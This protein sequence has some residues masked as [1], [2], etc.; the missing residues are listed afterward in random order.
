MVVNNQLLARQTLLKV[1]L[2]D[3]DA[4]PAAYT[5]QGWRV[6]NAEDVYRALS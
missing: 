5:G 3:P 1:E 2:V 6:L 4:L